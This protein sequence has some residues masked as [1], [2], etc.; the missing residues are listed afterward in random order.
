V[1]QKRHA[2]D[3]T[4]TP[5]TARGQRARKVARSSRE[6][7]MATAVPSPSG[8]AQS[9]SASA[10]ASASD[11]VHIRPTK[12]GSA[13]ASKSV[14]RGRSALVEQVFHR[15][16]VAPDHRV[17]TAAVNA[18]R[19]AQLTSLATRS[20]QLFTAATRAAKIDSQKLPPSLQLTL[21][22]LMKCV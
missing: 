7:S 10:S 20:P 21:I 12:V 14:V 22:N 18:D 16:A 8:G 9:A 19:L 15:I 5:D 11:A 3:P 6:H 4:E 1:L 13:A 17:D 2:A